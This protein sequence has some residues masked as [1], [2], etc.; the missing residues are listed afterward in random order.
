MKTTGIILLVTACT[1]GIYD[2]WAFLFMG[3]IS[4]ISAVLKEASLDYPGVLF[5]MAYICGHI[6]SPMK[7]T[8]CKICK[9]KLDG[10]M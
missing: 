5:A 7:S 1:I 3:E 6:F 4:T 9:E 2:L 10:R 8:R